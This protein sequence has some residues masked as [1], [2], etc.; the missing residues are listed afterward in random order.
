MYMRGGKASCFF[1]YQSSVTFILSVYNFYVENKYKNI[2]F[3]RHVSL[4]TRPN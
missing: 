3:A 1:Y 2:A 4:H